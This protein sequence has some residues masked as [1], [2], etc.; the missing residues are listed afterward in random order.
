MPVFTHLDDDRA[1]MVD[2]S[3]KG[4]VYRRAVAEGTI[5]LRPDTL[6]AIRDGTVIKGN[7]LA[8]ARVAATLA[9]KDTPRIIP[10][11]HAIP[12]HGID[13]TFDFTKTGISAQVTVI[14]AGKTGVEMEALVGV[15]TALLTI[16]DMVKSAEKDE[17]G[18]YPVTGI[19][20]IRVL[21]KVKQDL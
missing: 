3:A 17:K 11:C 9:V 5:N 14:S 4:E 18:Q 7:V 12:V 2:V 21:E 15:S 13:I 20:D 10:M 8:T 6:K 19:T 1:R 16:W